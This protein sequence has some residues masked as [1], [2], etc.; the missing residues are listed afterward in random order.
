MRLTPFA[1]E[2]DGAALFTFPGEENE[3]QRVRMVRGRVKTMAAE[4][5][6]SRKRIPKKKIR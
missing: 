4:R 5:K 2:T 6:H 1:R 3:R